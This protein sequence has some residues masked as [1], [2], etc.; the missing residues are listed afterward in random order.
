MS[1]KYPYQ[2]LG[3][4]VPERDVWKQ[5]QLL[6]LRDREL[7]LERRF[8][9]VSQRSV[10]KRNWRKRVRVLSRRHEFQR[11]RLQEQQLVPCVHGR[12]VSHGVD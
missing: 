2:R 10:L 9:P 4:R 3:V 12:R 8:N 5:H 7:L 1:V 11:H 6:D